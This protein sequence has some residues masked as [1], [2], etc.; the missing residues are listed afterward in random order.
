MRERRLVSMHDMHIAA[1]EV[2]LTPENWSGPVTI[3]SALDGRVV[4]VGAQLHRRFSN[5]H[6]EPVFSEAVDDTGVL[7]LVRTNQS[8]LYV[9]EAGRTD[10]HVNSKRVDAERSLIDE[11]GYIGHEVTFNVVQ[12]QTITV[13]TVVA[14]YTSRDHGISEPALEARKAIRRAGAFDTLLADH[15][16]T[17]KQLW[18]RFDVHIAP[19]QPGKL[20]VL[21]LLRLN[22]LHLL[23]T[24]SPHSIGLDIG[25]P[26]RGWT[27]E[28]YQGHVFWDELFIFP[29]LNYRMPD[30]TVAVDVPLSPV[31]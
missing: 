15:V 18:R 31:G 10:V 30:H 14:L 17:W 22:M 12:G 3:R 19:V 20:N 4:N 23:Q 5:R 11:P 6:L 26:A 8:R 21:L 1:L 25:V 7:L 29:F 9:A 2:S 27:G 16:R 24:T 28:P 13:E